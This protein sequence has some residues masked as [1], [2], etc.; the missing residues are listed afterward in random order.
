MQRDQAQKQLELLKRIAVALEKG[1]V[2]K[3]VE[4]S[5]QRNTELSA[6]GVLD[7][8]K[9]ITDDYASKHKDI[10]GFEGTLDQ[11]DALTNMTEARDYYKE[12]Y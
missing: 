12:K 2:T 7:A 8:V 11:L 5:G 1:N 4:L 3:A 6:N 10:P 9:V